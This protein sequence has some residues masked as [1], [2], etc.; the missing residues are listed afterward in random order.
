MGDISKRGHGIERRN[1]KRENR[2]EELG[3]VDAEKGYTRKGK[4]NLKEEKRRIVKE[5][6]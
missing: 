4:K 2:L 1:T 6:K 3:R 5:L